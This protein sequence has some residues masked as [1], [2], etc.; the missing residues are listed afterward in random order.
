MRE[1]DVQEAFLE[2]GYQISP[3]AADLI[4]SHSSPE[5]LVCYVLE[6]V[7]ESIFVIEAEHIDV[8]SFESE[9]GNTLKD[10][11]G[12][13]PEQL[14]ETTPQITVSTQGISVEEAVEAVV[15]SSTITPGTTSAMNSPASSCSKKYSSSF[16]AG[17]G[18]GGGI[19]RSTGAG[20]NGNG[21]GNNINIMSDITDMSTC[22]GEYMEFVQYFRNRYSKLSDLIRGRITARPIESLNKNRKHGGGLRRSGGDDYSEVSIIG[23]V[24]EVRSTANGHKML[25]LEDPTGSFLVLV[26][27]AEKDLFEEASKIIL[28]EVIG[29]SGSLTND[30]SLIVAKKIILPDLPN[31]SHRREGTWG[32]A[33]FTSDVHIGSSTFLEEEWCSFLDFL[34]GRSD[35]EQMREL[36]K[37]IRFLVIA[38]D[39]VDGIGIFPGQEHELDILDIYDQYAKAAEYFSQVPE[40]IQIIISP[41]NHDAVRQAEPQPRFPERITSLFEDRIIFVGN[42]ALVDL[43]GVQVLMYHGRSID[44]LVASVP[45][46]SYQEPEKA[47]IEMLKRRHLSPIYG[48]RVSIAPEKQD[49]FVIDP[50]P[51][52]LHCGHVHTI[53]IGRYKNVLA[54]NSGTWQSQTEFQKRVNVMPT[55]AQVP[56]VDLST[57]KTSLLHF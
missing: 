19:D 17:Y 45:G 23:M 40:H 4:V 20:T 56:V 51:D 5:D 11:S 9:C 10:G 41:G 21:A 3:E 38:G 36:S 12:K 39:L 13:S 47:L 46:V 16:P 34:N 32:K 49:H 42:P 22:V 52:I 53:G 25:Q 2:A 57:L 24:S 28:D 18:S 44:D 1:I 30:G 8:L 37:D 33:V 35:N 31:I 27:Q 26:H 29:V 54:I 14:T 43:D 15:S 48:S 50:V 6:H 55:P 7:D